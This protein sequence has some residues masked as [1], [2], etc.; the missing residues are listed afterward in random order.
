MSGA[1]DSSEHAAAKPLIAPPRLT[2]ANACLVVIDLQQRLMPTIADAS[3]V[4]TNA[5]LFMRAV[6]LFGLPIAMSEHYVKGLGP[7]IDPVLQALPSDAMR[8]EKTRFSAV[9]GP[10][11]AWLSSH[12]RTEVLLCGIEAHVCVLQ[13]ALDLRARGLT[14]YL[15]TDAISAGQAQQ[16]APAFRRMEACGCVPTGCLSAMYELAGDATNPHFKGMLDLAKAVTPV[17]LRG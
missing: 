17:S 6:G 8:F 4:A 1:P 14:P 2:P 12:G 9:L 16:I 15:L 3:A 7:T 5:A 10:L 11:T 13:T